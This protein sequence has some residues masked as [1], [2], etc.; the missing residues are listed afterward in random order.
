M[1]NSQPAILA[2]ADGKI[3]KGESVGVEG[4]TCGEV[5]FNTAQTGYQEILTD[6]SYA[7]QM[8]VFTHPH[9]GNVGVNAKDMESE[10][11][12]AVATIMRQFS[13]TASN[14]RS[15]KTLASFIREQN[16]L[17]MTHVDTRALTQY[18]RHHGSQMACMMTGKVEVDHAIYLARQHKALSQEILMQA[19]S[20]KTQQEIHSH[21]AHYHIVVLDFGVKN[22]ILTMLAQYHCKI[23]ILPYT[24]T[25]SDIL[26]LQPDGIVLSNGPGDPALLVNAI[27]TI[28]NLLTKDIPIMAICLGHQLL[29][30]ASGAKT[31]KMLFGHHGANHPVQSLSGGV[32]ITSQNHGFTVSDDDLPASL[33]IT[34]RSLFDQTIAGIE[35][36]DVPAFGFQ[37]HPEAGPGPFEMNV[38]FAKFMNLLEGHCAKT[39]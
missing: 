20:R 9:I 3:F 33:N 31:Q 19:V 1:L 11:M 32:A 29:A 8:I 12:H 13:E 37:G 34:H 24:T 23:T 38:L 35:R 27:A 22:S 10:K 28:K 18:L 25:V 15:E 36:K 26:A 2:F 17:A 21:N 30:L 6:P 39:N 7:G 16:K 5:V 4:T 14:W